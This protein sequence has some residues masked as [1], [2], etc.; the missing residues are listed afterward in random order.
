M[1]VQFRPCI[2]MG[3]YR[4]MLF[5]SSC[6]VVPMDDNELDA[7]A[8]QARI[9]VAMSAQYG[10]VDSWM[11]ASSSKAK[12]KSAAP[13]VKTVATSERFPIAHEVWK[14]TISAMGAL[15]HDMRAAV[16]VAFDQSSESM[17]FIH[18]YTPRLYRIDFKDVA[19]NSPLYFQSRSQRMALS[20]TWN[21]HFF[22]SFCIL[23]QMPVL[24]DSGMIAFSGQFDCIIPVLPR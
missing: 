21:T 1:N 6:S 16:S 3:S 2:A 20:K 17:Q 7:D 22:R 19:G 10:L 14:T 11:S 8:I 4:N 24:R 13:P 23:P 5:P 18:D 9:D 12:A 15:L